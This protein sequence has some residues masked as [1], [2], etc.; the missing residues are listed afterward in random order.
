[1]WRYCDGSS[2][3]TSK[4]LAVPILQVGLT[5]DPDLPTLP[6]LSSLV[7]KPDL[8]IADLFG[9]IGMIRAW[10]GLAGLARPTRT[11]R[12]CGVAFTE[13]LKDPEYQAEA[14]APSNC[15]VLPTNGDDLAKTIRDSI[16]NA[17]AAVIERTARPHHAQMIMPPCR[18]QPTR[19][20]QYA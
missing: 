3:A 17:D 14:A 1:L 18:S 6:I 4:K 9:V 20:W 15:A 2:A 7:A 11:C 16:N 5:P 8:R 19:Q 13:M 12:F 10:P